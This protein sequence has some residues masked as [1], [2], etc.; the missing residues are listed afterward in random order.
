MKELVR[1]FNRIFQMLIL[2]LVNVLFVGTFPRFFIIKKRLLNL[3]GYNIGNQTKIV[4]PI[5]CNANITIGNNCWLGKYLNVLGNG[6]VIIGDN[7]DI[8][9]EVKIITGSHDIG[10]DGRRAGQ[11]KSLK[12]IIKSGAWIGANV[13]IV[14]NCIIGEGSVI[15][16]GSVVVKDVPA[17]CVVVG[18]PSRIVKE[19]EPL[20]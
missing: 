6:Q 19:L 16:A 4:G 2:L 13:T 9:P 20:S 12:V 18:N 17:N 7:V 1:V 3:I 15:G 14:G 11:G 8:A 5:Y 10:K